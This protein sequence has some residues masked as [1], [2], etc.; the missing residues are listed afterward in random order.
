[1]WLPRRGGSGGAKDEIMKTRK[2]KG[3]E[4]RQ[5]E[6]GTHHRHRGEGGMALAAAGAGAVI[7]AHWQPA[8]ESGCQG[9]ARSLAD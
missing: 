7:L 5:T 4:R 3:I 1:M 9:H 2:G 8:A 6:T